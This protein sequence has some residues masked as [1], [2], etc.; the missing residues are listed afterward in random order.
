ME[1]NK[2]LT[3]NAEKCGSG[4]FIPFGV[5][6]LIGG[7]AK[8]FYAFI[9]ELNFNFIKKES[10]NHLKNAKLIVGFDAIA[11]TGEELNNPRRNIPLSILLTLLVVGGLYCG[12]SIVL[13]FMV[14]F[15]MMNIETP[16]PFAFDYVNLDWCKY[17]ATVGAII[18]LSTW[19]GPP[20]NYKINSKQTLI[21]ILI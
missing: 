18:S 2:T 5:D 19:L 10:I 17:I 9:G 12:L 6:G 3:C 4:G 11:S 16:L 21:L 15:Y 20:K 14:P 13:T 7:A 8:C 1:D